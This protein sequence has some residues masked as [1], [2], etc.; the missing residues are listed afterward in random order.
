M[1]RIDEARQAVADW[2]ER[3]P[4]GAEVTIDS[5]PTRTRD[6][7]RLVGDIPVVWVDDR[8]HAVALESVVPA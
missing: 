3:H 1:A 2:N 4:V 7:A 5:T 8:V 6:I